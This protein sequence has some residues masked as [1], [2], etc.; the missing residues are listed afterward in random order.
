MVETCV[1]E[2]LLCLSRLLAMGKTVELD[3]T[4]VG[5]LL[6]REK[7]VKMKFFKEFIRSLDNSG[8]IETNF[9]SYVHNS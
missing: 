7:K 5:R 2:L 1:R 6:L 3:F 8:S 9:V 4:G